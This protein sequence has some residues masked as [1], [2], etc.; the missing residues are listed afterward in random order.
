MT[1][2]VD[3]D[4]RLSAQAAMSKATLVEHKQDTHEEI[5]AERY[6]GIRTSMSDIKDLVKEQGR[7]YENGINRVHKR[8]DDGQKTFTGVLITLAVLLL[9]AVGV[10]AFFIMTKGV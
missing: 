5:C 4:A 2:A 8:I 1:T 9:S 7:Q 6:E 10:L 3:G